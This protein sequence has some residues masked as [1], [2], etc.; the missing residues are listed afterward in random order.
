MDEPVQELFEFLGSWGVDTVELDA[1]VFEGV[2]A[3]ENQHVEMNIKIE[4]TTEALYQGNGTGTSATGH[5]ETCSLGEIGLD[6][7]KDDGKTTAEDIRAVGEEQTQG[8]GETQHPL[9]NRYRG[10][11]MIDQMCCGLDHAPGATGRTKTA[12]FARERHEMF[13]PATVA[14]HPQKTVLK[15]A[16]LQV[17]VEFVCDECRPSAAL[18]M[19]HVLLD[20]CI[21]CG[22]LGFVASVPACSGQG[23][24]KCQT[25]LAGPNRRQRSRRSYGKCC[26]KRLSKEASQMRYVRYAMVPSAR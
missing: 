14:F 13:V 20:D 26:G 15:E 1:V 25:K 18:A 17:L 5:L 12:S 7:P 23:P 9:P 19:G 2:D 21:E 16:T 6:G 11:D 4:S 8:P 3:V 10:N 22:L 24:G